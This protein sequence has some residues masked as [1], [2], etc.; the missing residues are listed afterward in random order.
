MTQSVKF[1]RAEKRFRRKNEKPLEFRINPDGF[2]GLIQNHQGLKRNS[3][4]F[5]Y[6]LR[7]LFSALRNLK[8]V[9]YKGFRVCIQ[10]KNL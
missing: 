5:A 8:K 1:R 4:G 3:K 2:V 9:S 7:N 10:G 6:F